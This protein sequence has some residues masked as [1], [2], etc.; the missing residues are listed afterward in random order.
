MWERCGQPP[1]TSWELCA[2]IGVPE[3]DIRERLPEFATPTHEVVGAS[4]IRRPDAI[5]LDYLTAHTLGPIAVAD[6]SKGLVAR[7][8]KAWTPDG[9]AVWLAGADGAARD[10]KSTRLN[11]SH[12]KIS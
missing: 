1:E 8:W 12:V 3:P 7:I 11:S 10:R 2:V 9:F 5:S 6:P 4:I